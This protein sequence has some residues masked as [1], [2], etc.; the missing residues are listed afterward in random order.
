MKVEEFPHTPSSY[1]MRRNIALYG[2]E[3]SQPAEMRV[4]EN[5]PSD[6]IEFRSGRA[7]FKI[8]VKRVPESRD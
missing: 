4:A 8:K 6:K 2:S 1:L 5:K 3:L 7:L